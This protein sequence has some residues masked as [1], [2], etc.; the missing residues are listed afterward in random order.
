M[1]K[2]LQQEISKHQVVVAKY[3]KVSEKIKFEQA[4]KKKEGTSKIEEKTTVEDVNIGKAKN[5]GDRFL[6]V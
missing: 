3:Q 2:K 4:M 6:K 1:K 5:L